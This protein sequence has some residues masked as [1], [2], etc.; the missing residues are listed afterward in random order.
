[1]QISIS[2][3][4]CRFSPRRT[5][6][7]PYHIY[8]NV[9]HK[10]IIIIIER[11][12]HHLF[13]YAMLTAN[14]TYNISAKGRQAKIMFEEVE[15]RTPRKWYVRQRADDTRSPLIFYLMH[16]TGFSD[17]KSNSNDSWCLQLQQ[18]TKRRLKN[19]YEIDS[20]VSYIYIYA[21]GCFCRPSVYVCVCTVHARKI[22]NM[23]S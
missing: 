20:W 1:M 19:R 9:C 7:V 8:E 12:M 13:E 23:F 10:I 15:K 17:A 14:N 21:N 6:Y 22:R 16:S 2:H 11:W 3:R 4:R 5:T 18:H